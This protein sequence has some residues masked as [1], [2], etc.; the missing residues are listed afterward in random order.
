[1]L[2]EDLLKGLVFNIQRFSIHDGPGIRTL[3]FMKGC[4]L[5]CLWCSNPEG[6]SQQTSIMSW[7]SRCICCGACEKVC[8]QSAIRP[9]PC[10]RGPIRCLGCGSCSPMPTVGDDYDIDRTLCNSCGECARV[11]PTN[12]KKVCGEYKTVGEIIG[13]IKRDAPFYRHSS[14]GVTMG[15]GEVLMQPEFT[16]EVLKQ[17]KEHGINTAIETCGHGSKEWLKKFAMYCD[18]IHFDI[19]A[20]DSKKHKKLTGV[21]NKVILENLIALDKMLEEMS[22]NKPDLV[23]RLPLVGGYNDSKNDIQQVTDFIKGNLNNISLIEIMPFHNLG[24]QKYIQLGMQYGL[25]G[26]PNTPKGTYDW[27]V[28]ILEQTG[29]LVKISMW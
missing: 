9:K 13:V 25:K 3:V 29:I 27:V 5:E 22:E 7:P 16:Y 23:I 18:T 24:E 14:G 20:I 11:C 17:S 26:K 28:E 2:E 1:M 19:K 12:A 21:D 6:L 10:P 8:P 15:G 4:P